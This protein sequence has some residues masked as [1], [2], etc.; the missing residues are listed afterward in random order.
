MC[1]S[2]T[3]LT[4]WILLQFHPEPISLSHHLI[5]FPTTPIFYG[6]ISWL[7]TQDGYPQW[8]Y[9]LP[10]HTEVD[11]TLPAH[12]YHLPPFTGCPVFQPLGITC[13]PLNTLSGGVYHPIPSIQKD[14][15]SYE[16]KPI[17]HSRCSWKHNF[18]WEILRNSCLSSLDYQYFIFHC[19]LTCVTLVCYDLPVY[20][21]CHLCSGAQWGKG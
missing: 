5:H 11:L 10:Q 7:A 13:P 4:F 15:L 19:L 1:F 17:H 21:L 8:V 20:L 14:L 12:P 18:I 2:S 6:I 3:S 16:E 9:N